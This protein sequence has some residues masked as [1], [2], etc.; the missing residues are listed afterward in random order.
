MYQVMQE[1]FFFFKLQQFYVQIREIRGKKARYIPK[2][3]AKVIICEK[4]FVFIKKN[5]IC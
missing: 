4:L 1:S 3:E 5:R 2:M